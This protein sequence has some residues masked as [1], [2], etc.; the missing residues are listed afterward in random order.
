MIGGAT[1]SKLHTAIKIAP[2]YDAPVI[3][4]TDAAQ[5]PLIA[6]KL[7]NPATHDA[8]VDK[9]D[10]EYQTLRDS[11]EKTMKSWFRSLMPAPTAFR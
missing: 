7:L 3:H 10:K 6:A 1:T 9:L 11:M 4:V 5:N 8:F 2:R